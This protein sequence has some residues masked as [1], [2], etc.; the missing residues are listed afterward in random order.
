M[1]RKVRLVCIILLVLYVCSRIPTPLVVI[2]LIGCLVVHVS[3]ELEE[4][5][6][7]KAKNKNRR[8]KVTKSTKPKKSLTSL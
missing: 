2:P 3:K 5:K 8:K 4:I 1:A 7:D 6:N